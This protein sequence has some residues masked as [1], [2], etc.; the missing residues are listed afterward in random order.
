[1]APD[2]T[3]AK[4]L[5]KKQ[6]DRF[7]RFAIY[8]FTSEPLK[9]ASHKTIYE[10]NQMATNYN[11]GFIHEREIGKAHA[12]TATHTYEEFKNNPILVYELLAEI[13]EQLAGEKSRLM[14]QTITEVTTLTGNTVTGG[15]EVTSEDILRMLDKI[16]MSF[17]SN[18]NPSR[19]TFMTSPEML[20][21][22]KS[23]LEASELDDNFKIR[24][25]AIIKRKRKEWNDRENLREL[26]G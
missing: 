15:S 5:L 4:S 3:R 6:H 22:W 11:E 24:R 26:V 12:E 7:L 23:V 21:K 8:H 9:Q 1:M 16:E 17:D 10:G 13:A 14:L 19:Y 20:P 18:G 25:E 2:F